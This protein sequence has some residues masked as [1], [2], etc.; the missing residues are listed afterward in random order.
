MTWKITPLN[1][2]DAR[3]VFGLV[4][5]P[6]SFPESFAYAAQLFKLLGFFQQ[7]IP[8][9][10][11]LTVAVS[12]IFTLL[13]HHI[14]FSLIDPDFPNADKDPKDVLSDILCRTKFTERKNT[15]LVFQR[16]RLSFV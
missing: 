7:L 2:A 8:N 3:F 5:Q 4:Q 9:A 14:S 15:F 10:T 16:F 11:L 13:C 12:S 1:H 6:V